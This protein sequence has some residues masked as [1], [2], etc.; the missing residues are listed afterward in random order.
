[1]SLRFCMYIYVSRY[2]KD[3]YGV[4]RTIG[5]LVFTSMCKLIRQGERLLLSLFMAGKA[6]DFDCRLFS[7]V[8]RVFA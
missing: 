1:M 6:P 4:G 3:A 5:R 7:S 8:R 2:R